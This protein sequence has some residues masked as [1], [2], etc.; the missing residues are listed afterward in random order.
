M[1]E[2]RPLSTTGHWLQRLLRL[3]LDAFRDVATDPGATVPMLAVVTAASFAT[4]IGSWL[5]WLFQSRE[6]AG[7]VFVKSALLGSLLQVP[8]WLLWVY[9]TYQTLTLA[10]GVRADFYGLVRAMGLAFAP[11]ALTVLMAVAQLA[12]PLAVIPLAATLLLSLV[13]V[14]AASD[15]ET[16]HA[17]LATLAG[18]AAFA[19]VMGILANIAEVEGVGGVAPGLFFFALDF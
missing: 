18:F 12:V 3:D 17:L 15:G 13:A 5:W 6:A 8:A 14:E 11:M 2:R 7:E 1:R 4:G 16:G 9:V 19:L 10:F